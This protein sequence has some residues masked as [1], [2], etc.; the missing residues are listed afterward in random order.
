MKCNSTLRANLRGNLAA[1]GCCLRENRLVV[2]RE[3]ASV[4][5]YTYDGDGRKRTEQASG[6]PAV[7]LV[8]DGDDYL[9]ARS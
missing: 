4:R 6:S 7:T 5:T 9:Q 2:H 3:G 1:P 8:R